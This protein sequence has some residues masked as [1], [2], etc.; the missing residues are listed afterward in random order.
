VGAVLDVV[1]HM[2]VLALHSNTA[3]T[4]L[5]HFDPHLE[6]QAQLHA[7][8]VLEVVLRRQVLVLSNTVTTPLLPTPL[9]T[10]PLIQ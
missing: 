5:F 10:T 2:Q 8:A 3:K 9:L 1:L 7:G 4:S 6:K